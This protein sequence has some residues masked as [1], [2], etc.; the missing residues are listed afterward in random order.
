[1]ALR[2]DKLPPSGMKKWKYNP[3]CVS[4][5]VSISDVLYEELDID[6]DEMDFE[7]EG[8]SASDES[9]CEM[10]ESE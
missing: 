2:S 4:D 7:N 6:S 5:E 10:S 1:M 9:S 8:E 3:V